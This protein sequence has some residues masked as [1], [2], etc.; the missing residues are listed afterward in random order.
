MDTSTT[1]YMITV[2]D[3]HYVIVIYIRQRVRHLTTKIKMR[4]GLE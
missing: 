1:H 3:V 4:L 2:L